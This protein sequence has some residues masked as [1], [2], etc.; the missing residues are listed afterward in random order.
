[1][2]RGI[3]R[4]GFIRGLFGIKFIGEFFVGNVCG[5]DQSGVWNYNDMITW[6]GYNL[7][8]PG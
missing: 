5:I 3:P 2:S 4:G 1:M 6:K 7:G 8:H